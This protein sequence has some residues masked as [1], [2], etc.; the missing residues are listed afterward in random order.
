M[1][2]D[3]RRVGS[4]ASPRLEEPGKLSSPRNPRKAVDSTKDAL[5]VRPH[6]K[7]KDAVKDGAQGI[8]DEGREEGLTGDSCRDV[9]RVPSALP[10]STDVFLAR[11]RAIA[12]GYDHVKLAVTVDVGDH[13]AFRGHARQRAGGRRTQRRHGRATPRS[14]PTAGPYRP[15]R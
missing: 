7:I 15:R 2:R 13:H 10:V 12:G 5:D 3:R 14:G 1:G 8:K 6:E 4:D 9:F 11:Q